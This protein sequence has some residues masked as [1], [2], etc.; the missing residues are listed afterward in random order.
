MLLRMYE[1]EFASQFII[2]ESM[3]DKIYKVKKY[4]LETYSKIR[5]PKP[6]IP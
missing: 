5:K 2:G 3:A 4:F 6:D 1:I